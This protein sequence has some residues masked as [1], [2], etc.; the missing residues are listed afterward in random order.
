MD[1]PRTD[2]TGKVKDISVIILCWVVI[3]FLFIL[4]QNTLKPA[5]KVLDRTEKESLGKLDH[6]LEGLIRIEKNIETVTEPAFLED[7][8]FEPMNDVQGEL[9][10]AASHLSE[11]A[12]KMK[13]AADRLEQT[14]HTFQELGENLKTDT[15]PHT[16]RGI[17]YN[18]MGNALEESAALLKELRETNRQ[19]QV[20]QER[21]EGSLT[22]A[23]RRMD[24]ITSGFVNLSLQYEELG[25]R[26]TRFSDPKNLNT[27]FSLREA[28]RYISM[29]LSKSAAEQDRTRLI[30][31]IDGL[32]DEDMKQRG[33]NVT[34]KRKGIELDDFNAFERVRIDAVSLAG[35]R[36][37]ELEKRWRQLSNQ[38]P[39]SKIEPEDY[40]RWSYS[41]EA[42]RHLKKRGINMHEE[43]DEILERFPDTPD[44]ALAMTPEALEAIREDRVLR[45]V[46]SHI[47][48]RKLTPTVS[49]TDLP[50]LLNIPLTP[51]DIIRK[52][53][54]II[55]TREK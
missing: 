26:L 1:K 6:A 17:I 23:D 41:L 49:G 27:V 4:L 9:K 15:D 2:I 22:S 52:E 29:P 19:F 8:F 3:A 54:P 21:M 32:L 13:G 45:R 43:L 51:I 10:E 46:K 20:F 34:L 14:L 40:L 47:I 48:I 16:L 18:P 25:D 37:S 24:D 44:I 11:T 39:S 30:V 33:F 55:G 53:I 35:K 28:A 12:Q 7:K 50:F 31:Q 36:G 5:G 38:N 42:L